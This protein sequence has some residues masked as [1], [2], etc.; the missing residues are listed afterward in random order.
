MNVIISNELNF[1]EVQ[2]LGLIHFARDT[3][4]FIPS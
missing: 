1:S 3:V 2:S 4:R